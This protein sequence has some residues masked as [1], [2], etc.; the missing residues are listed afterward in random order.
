MED[1]EESRTSRQS[2][3]FAEH[4]DAANRHEHADGATESKEGTWMKVELSI[5]YVRL[6]GS[7]CT[8]YV[9]DPFAE[10]SL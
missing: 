1:V 7:S 2:K 4:V 10:T 3:V 6:A 9:A 5:V 8:H